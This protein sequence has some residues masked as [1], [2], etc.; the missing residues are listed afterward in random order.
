[1]FLQ[2]TDQQSLSEIYIAV[3]HMAEST[4]WRRRLSYHL[5]ILL[6][7]KVPRLQYKL[8]SRVISLDF[9]MQLRL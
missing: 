5:F 9:G 6:R 4:Y 1:M 8:P 2:F 7:L 3:P